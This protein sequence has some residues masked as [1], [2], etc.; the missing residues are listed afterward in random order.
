M[1]FW[2][3]ETPIKSAIDCEECTINNNLYGK[4]EIFFKK[5]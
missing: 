2:R 3:N 4:A 1:K 5:I